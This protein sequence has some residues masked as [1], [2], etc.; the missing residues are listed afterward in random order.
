[1][2][3]II[4]IISSAAVQPPPTPHPLQ[5]SHQI[6]TFRMDPIG[7]LR[8]PGSPASYAAGRTVLVTASSNKA[9]PYAINQR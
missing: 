2:I 9:L 6:F 8:G 5:K 1:M 3:I 4:V 7:Q